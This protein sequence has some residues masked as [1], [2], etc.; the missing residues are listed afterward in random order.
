[1]E[2][3]GYFIFWLKYSYYAILYKLQAYNVGIH[4]F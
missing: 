1:M 3:K 4:N 2:V